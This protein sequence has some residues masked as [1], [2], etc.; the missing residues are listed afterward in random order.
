MKKSYEEI[1]QENKELKEDRKLMLKDIKIFIKEREKFNSYLKQLN[2]KINEIYNQKDINFIQELMRN[3]P[4]FN[5]KE[6]LV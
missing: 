6:F 5:Y 3:D 2:K 4:L 1:L